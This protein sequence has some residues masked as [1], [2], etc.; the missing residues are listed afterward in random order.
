[1]SFFQDKYYD[2]GMTLRT[3]NPGFVVY[4]ALDDSIRAS[5]FDCSTG[6]QP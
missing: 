4:Q 5:L 3:T 2:H 6:T 1:M